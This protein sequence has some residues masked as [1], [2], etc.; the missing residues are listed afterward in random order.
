MRTRRDRPV[1]GGACLAQVLSVLGAAEVGGDPEGRR[2]ASS[3]FSPLGLERS[4]ITTGL[5]PAT[6]R[7]DDRSDAREQGPGCRPL[8][9]NE[10]NL[11]SE[12]S[13][14]ES[15][16]KGGLPGHISTL[17][18]TS[19]ERRLAKVGNPTCRVDNGSGSV[20]D[21]LY[22]F[23]RTPPV[24]MSVPGQKPDSSFSARM[25]PSAECGHWSPLRCLS[26]GA[27]TLRGSDLHSEQT[28]GGTSALGS[29]PSARACRC[30]A[31]IS[32]SS[33]AML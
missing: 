4:F 29:A 14:S 17:P 21:P 32:A 16:P 12:P 31:S 30:S 1:P 27:R 9:V 25:S 26:G 33:S 10:L 13:L 5:F 3:R 15:A 18:N 20:P 7:A 24:R 11:I 22:P 19:F 8:P 23:H 6:G 28:H 2:A